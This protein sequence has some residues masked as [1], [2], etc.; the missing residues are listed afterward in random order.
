M[1]RALLVLFCG[2]ALTLLPL[3][4]RAADVDLP[5]Y[6]LR[7]ATARDALTQAQSLAG[8]QRDA[9]IQRA[10]DALTGIDNV[11][12]DGQRYPT[13]HGDA[14]DALRRT[15]PEI[16]R[17]SVELT[18][19]HAL[20]TNAQAAAPDTRARQRLDDVLRDR[21]FHEAEPNIVQRQVIRAQSWV[22][23]QV[24][25]LFRP[26]QR[27]RPPNAPADTPGAGPLA[28]LFAALGSPIIL[29]LLVLVLAAVIAFF[30]TRRFRTRKKKAKEEAPLPPRT[31]AE[32]WQHADALA[33]RGDYRAA[34]R[35]LFLGTLTELD[36]R[37]LVPFD[38]ALTDREYLREAQRQQRWLIEPL[39]PFVRLVEE[40]VYANA[41]CHAA[42]YATAR[43]YMDAVRRSPNPAP[44]AA[45]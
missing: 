30:I 22:G 45:V 35:A 6:V 28:R 25:R 42:E 5:T 9:A 3:S 32:W 7:L 1:R 18:T 14:L 19:L 21:A 27:A 4:A 34:I 10:Q 43:G 41:P 44:E 26:F 38:R 33:T 13:A 37:R 12:I 2:L 23:E 24:R 8:A 16:E 39:R 29:I 20:M 31:A 15:P 11:T 40:I 17:A 36:E